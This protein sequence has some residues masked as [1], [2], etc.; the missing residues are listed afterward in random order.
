M[1]I[2]VVHAFILFAGTEAKV[3]EFVV[4]HFL[5]CVSKDA[6]GHETI[7][8]IDVNGEKVSRNLICASGKV[9]WGFTLVNLL[10]YL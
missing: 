6:Q 4:R 7:V 2:M 10:L 8:N 1:H 3:Y 5:A 9:F